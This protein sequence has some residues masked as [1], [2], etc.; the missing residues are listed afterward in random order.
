[1]SILF[2]MHLFVTVRAQVERKFQQKKQVIPGEH[3]VKIYMRMAVLAGFGWTIGFILFLL[4][5]GNAGFK[6]YLVTIFKYLFIL[7]NA[8]PGLFI[9]VVYV[10]N[11][12][13]WALYRR[14]WTPI[15]T[16]LHRLK[17]CVCH[18]SRNC[19][20]RMKN[21]LAKFRRTID[22]DP[23]AIAMKSLELSDQ[24]KYTY[25]LSKR[26]DRL[27]SITSSSTNY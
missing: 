7:L 18:Q 12:R 5:D 20:D 13:V 26:Q 15:F 3:D 4:P 21:K 27:S 11:R 24:R 16:Y 1:M 2:A 8:T 25:Y 22:N 23:M 6:L 17:E 14:L 9:F 19:F 10:C